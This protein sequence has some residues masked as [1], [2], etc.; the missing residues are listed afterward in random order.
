MSVGS[1]LP[2]NAG[3]QTQVGPC[4]SPLASR[5]LVPE[6]ILELIGR[7]ARARRLE[8]GIKLVRVGAAADKSEGSL[9]RFEAGRNWQ[10]LDRVVSAYAEE[11]GMSPYELWREALDLWERDSGA[12]SR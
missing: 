2:Q 3:F 9:A 5:A 8:R 6:G 4:P 1:Q 10:E 11:V 7:V 12:G